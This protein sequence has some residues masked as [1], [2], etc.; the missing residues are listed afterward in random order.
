MAIAFQ[1]MSLDQK[2]YNPFSILHYLYNQN[3]DN[4]WF[5]SGTPTF[6]I[7]LIKKHYYTPEYLHITDV[8]LGSASLGTFD[9]DSVPPLYTL[10]FQTG[11][12][13]IKSFDEALKSYTLTYPN[14]EVRNSIALYLISIITHKDTQSIDITATAMKSAL[15]K[16]DLETFCS[17]LQSLLASIPYNLYV[18]NE[19]YFHSLLYPITRLL[20]MDAKPEEPTNKGRIDLAILT[21][22]NIYVFELKFNASAHEA[23]QQIQ[24]KRYYEKY[25]NR[26][27]SITLVGLSFN[28][29]D[30]IITLDW[31]THQLNVKT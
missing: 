16:H 27:K 31:V 1:Q 24:D 3:I 25:L 8:T 21:A 28:Y 29:E 5:E 23:L 13:T 19:A 9:I 11:Y 12:L 26:N 7:E 6:L 22:T 18:N 10:L 30:K 17:H 20:G 15:E 2:I 4:Y 14:E